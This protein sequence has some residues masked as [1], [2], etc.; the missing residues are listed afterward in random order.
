MSSLTLSMVLHKQLLARGWTW[1]E[2]H[3]ALGAAGCKVT[4][5]TVYNW[6]DGISP[7]RKHLRAIANVLGVPHEQV[8]LATHGLLEAP[9][10]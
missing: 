8:V 7:R 6:R 3:R 1:A 4:L 5:P 10:A 2:F 9:A